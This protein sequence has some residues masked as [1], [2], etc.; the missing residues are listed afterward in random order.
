MLG[1]VEVFNFLMEAVGVKNVFK[2]DCCGQSPLQIA[3]VL[4][5]PE[6]IKSLLKKV[7]ILEFESQFFLPPSLGCRL[8]SP[9]S[10]QVRQKRWKRGQ[11]SATKTLKAFG[12]VPKR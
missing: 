6:K 11:Q 10:M 3:K 7:R 1:Q 4:F 9:R 12:R 5:P 2:P 8:W